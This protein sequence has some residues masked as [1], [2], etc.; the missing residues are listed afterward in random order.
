[1]QTRP[2]TYGMHGGVALHKVTFLVGNI[3]PA[4]QWEAPVI[5]SP[6]AMMAMMQ[7]MGPPEGP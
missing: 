3:T 6:G 5:G 7:R 2:G 4:A 1:M